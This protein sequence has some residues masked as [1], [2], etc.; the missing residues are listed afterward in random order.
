MD[1][2]LIEDLLENTLGDYSFHSKWAIEFQEVEGNEQYYHVEI[3]SY[4]SQ[5]SKMLHFKII[6]EDVYIETGEDCYYL[7]R[8]WD[9]TI[10]NFWIVFL[11]SPFNS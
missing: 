5:Q 7:V 9:E 6:D 10:E 4:N 2:K 3:I 1:E 11:A 8:Y